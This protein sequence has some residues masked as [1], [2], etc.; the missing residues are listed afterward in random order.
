MTAPVAHYL[1]LQV[2]VEE[3]EER[4]LLV[5]ATLLT[6]AVDAVS[7]SSGVVASTGGTGSPRP[8]SRLEA[9]TTE[10]CSELLALLPP[11]TPAVVAVLLRLHTRLLTQWAQG[12]QVRT[13]L[14][15][16]VC[17]VV[18][19]TIVQLCGLL[20]L[21]H[22]QCFP[23]TAA[24]AMVSTMPWSGSA[25]TGPWDQPVLRYVDPATCKSFHVSD[26]LS[27]PRCQFVYHYLS[28]AHVPFVCTRCRSLVSVC[29]P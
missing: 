21:G 2:Q 15:V 18:H 12:S 27:S 10:A 20:S 9:G 29:T 3:E 17:R 19:W 13:T 22:V 4:L 8:A 6:W 28:H 11:L 14:V 24:T 5:G 16:A 7:N 23:S 25:L 26:L 1:G